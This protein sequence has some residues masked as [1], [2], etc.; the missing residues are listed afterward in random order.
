MVDAMLVVD[1]LEDNGAGDVVVA[2]GALVGPDV[3]C[4]SVSFITTCAVGGEVA[5]GEGKSEVIGSVWEGGS[6]RY[7]SASLELLSVLSSR[8]LGKRWSVDVPPIRLVGA[9]AC[10]EKI[11]ATNT[12]ALIILLAVCEY[13]DR[14]I[15]DQ[16]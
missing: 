5:I 6:V 12:V 13:L 4:K 1:S 3:I 16:R 10:A 2:I 15:L 14:V 9:C 7:Q 8:P 11:A